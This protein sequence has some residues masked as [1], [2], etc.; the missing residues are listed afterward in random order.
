MQDYG[1]GFWAEPDLKQTTIDAVKARMSELEEDAQ[2]RR[3]INAALDQMNKTGVEK[4]ADYA[5]DILPRYHATETPESTP[6][7]TTPEEKPPESP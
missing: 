4:V 3:R 5:E 1:D 7:D 6:I 2:R